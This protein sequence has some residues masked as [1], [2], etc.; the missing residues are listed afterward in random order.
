M[1][2]TPHSLFST[3]SAGSSG[4]WKPTNAAAH[5]TARSLVATA[6]STPSA[7]RGDSVDVSPLGKAL[8]GVAAKMFEKLDG[9]AKAMLEDSVKAGVLTADDV[10][11]GLRGIVKEAVDHRYMATAPATQEEIASARERRETTERRLKFA[12]E[13]AEIM[14][15]HSEKYEDLAKTL[16]E[17][18]EEYRTESQ[19]SMK[20]LMAS[21]QAHKE[22]FIRQYGEIDGKPGDGSGEGSG[23]LPEAAWQRRLS[24]NLRHADIFADEEDPDPFS[25]SDTAAVQKLFDAGFRQ[26][27]YKDAATAVAAG[28]DLSKV[29]DLPTPDAPPRQPQ[30]QQPE[31]LPPGYTSSADAFKTAWQQVLAHQ[32]E[33]PTPRIDMLL[34][35]PTAGADAALFRPQPGPPKPVPDE[36]DGKDGILAALTQSLKDGSGASTSGTAAARTDTV[37]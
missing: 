15:Q 5:G 19:D 4:V 17:N 31:T 6:F 11:K 9:K 32:A 30:N 27:M 23:D 37:V 24:N 21:L 35:M 29:P 26:G 12:K 36:A 1:S 2:L 16:P 22:N 28:V 14:R 7:Q 34:A 25:R 10:V 3:V 13:S 18:G 8:T 20:T 33:K